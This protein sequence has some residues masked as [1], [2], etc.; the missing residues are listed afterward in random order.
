[1]LAN[2]TKD[3][4][5]W[6]DRA[7]QFRSLAVKMSGCEAAILIGDLANDYDKI[8]YNSERQVTNDN[9]F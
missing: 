9:R 7:G 4:K 3:S 1:M 2:Q 5:Y 8:A 6:R